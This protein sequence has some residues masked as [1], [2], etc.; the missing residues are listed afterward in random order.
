MA[1]NPT[2]MTTYTATAAD[3]STVTYVDRK[4]WWW[5]LALTFPALPLIA[6]TLALASGNPNWIWAPLL[7]TFVAYPALDWLIGRDH[8]NPPEAVAM[9]LDRDPYYRRI[10]YAAVPLH[11]LTLLA[12]AWF[13]TR[14]GAGWGTYLGAALVGGMTAGLAI[15]TAHELGHKNSRLEKFLA[16]LVLAVPGYGHF[17]IDHNR[18]HHKHVATFADPASARMG[19]SLYRF[20]CREIPGALRSAWSIES[21]RLKNRGLPAWHHSNQVLRAHALTLVLAALLVILFGW[22]VLPFLLIHNAA[23]YWQLT[24]ANY[25]EHYGLLRK[26]DADGNLERCQLHHSWNCN[27]LFSNLVLL[28]LE[29]HSDHHAHPLRRFQSLRDHE[30]VPQ[31]PNGYFGMYGL[32]AVPPLWFRYMDRRLMALPQVGGDLDNVNVEPTARAELFL[33]WEPHKRV[34]PGL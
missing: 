24:S 19:E 21:T 30:H 3:G 34:E 12:C 5:L 22:Q 20:A 14:D 1:Y 10:T 27:F 26:T 31:L 28:H 9:Q 16:R 11:F 8:N 4:R 33:R 15:N 23:A 7:V 25:I 32:A 17:S 29:R 2:P 6:I 18:G 13:A